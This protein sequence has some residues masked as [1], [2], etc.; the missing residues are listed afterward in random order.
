MD[1]QNYRKHKG[2]RGRELETKK[3][4]KEKGKTARNNKKMQSVG[5]RLEHF[6]PQRKAKCPQRDI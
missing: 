3:Q 4:V 5:S 1:R 2:Q 6:R